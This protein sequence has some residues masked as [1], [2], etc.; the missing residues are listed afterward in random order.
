VELVGGVCLRRRVR[1]HRRG[2]AGAQDRAR[3]RIYTSGS[4]QADIKGTTTARRHNWFQADIK[5]TITARCR[6]NRL[7]AVD[8]LSKTKKEEV[9]PADVLGAVESLMTC[10]LL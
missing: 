1:G 9:S 4:V 10:L 8:F 5:C 2:A 7:T 6:N 3:T